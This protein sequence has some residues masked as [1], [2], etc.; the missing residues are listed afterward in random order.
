[1]KT[2][3][4]KAFRSCALAIA[5]FLAAIVSATGREGATGQENSAAENPPARVARLSFIKGSVSF[6]RASVQQWS[7]A[8]LN[9]PVTTGDRIYTDKGARTELQVGNF[10]VRLSEHTDLTVTNLNDQ[11]LQ[12]GLQEGTLRLSVYQLPSGGTIEVDTPNGAVTV[13]QPGEVRIQVDPNGDLTEVAV[14]S[15]SVELTGGGVSQTLQS[16]QA[17]KLTGHDEVAIVSIPLPKADDFD[18]W[19][20]ARDRHISSSKSARYVSRGIPG[21][22][23]LDE[24]GTWEDV[25]DYGPIWYPAG[26][27]VGWVPY[28]FGRWV[29]VGPWG[30]TWVEDEPWGFCQF[31]YGRWVHVGV[32]WGW[33]PGP[34][35]PGP[36]Y[37]PAFVAFV[38]GP[39]F[40]I[41]IGGGP[42]SL[43]AWFP[44]GPGEPFF[45]WYHCRETYIREVNITNVRNITN[46]TNIVNVTNINN[47]HYAYRSIA[48]TA[49]PANVLRNGAPVA[50]QMVRLTPQQLERA[51]I[52]PHPNVNPTLRAALPG[53]PVTPPPV[54]PQA[55]FTAA[56]EAPRA[57]RTPPPISRTAPISEKISPLAPARTAAPPKLITRVPPPPPHVPF[58]VQRQYMTQHPGRYLEPQQ[59]E[60]IRAGRRP[61]PMLDREFPPHVASPPHVRVAPPAPPRKQ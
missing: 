52:V 15:G 4:A 6:L 39:S 26:V 54:R 57:V 59:I 36:V 3:N 18:K 19:C 32:R 21:F 20:E 13:V 55:S 60:N 46:I 56:R 49:V 47:V 25:A 37:A 40:S 29:W 53:K 33:L 61:G 5:L 12:L 8:A 1:M 38:G 44:L 9:Y 2:R 10:T 48:T 7:D 50:R 34:I 23:D 51:Q 45:P 43:T 31:H 30:W 14:N 58:T 28:R 22:D 11:I 24:Y 27:V 16:G 42:V 17:A 41:T 35:V